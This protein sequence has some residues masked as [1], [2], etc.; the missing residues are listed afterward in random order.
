MEYQNPFDSINFRFDTLEALVLKLYTVQPKE[1]PEADILNIKQAAKLL[2]LAQG[3]IYNKVNRKEIPYFKKGKKIYFS[4]A[5]LIA[6]IKEGRKL[7]K[8]EI[9]EEVNKIICNQKKDIRYTLPERIK[10]FTKTADL[11]NQTFEEASSEA[12]EIHFNT[13]KDELKKDLK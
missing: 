11:E 1:E 3:T 7:I 2:N 5:G 12:G 8:I 4:K 10:K 6:W 13:Y 9:I